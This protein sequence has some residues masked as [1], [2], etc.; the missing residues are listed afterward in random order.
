[1]DRWRKSV[2]ALAQHLHKTVAEIESGMSLGEFI[3]WLEYFAEVNQ[4]A[5][6]KGEPLD[7]SKLSPSQL[8]ELFP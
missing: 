8:K 5:P 3:G 2:Y 1:M 4:D 7:V 6:Q